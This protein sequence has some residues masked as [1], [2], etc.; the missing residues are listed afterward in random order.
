MERH[1][2]L[3]FIAFVGLF[4]MPFNLIKAQE[5]NLNIQDLTSESINVKASQGILWKI[6]GKGLTQASYI[7]AVLY[8]VPR[9]Q[10]FLHPSL[11]SV[12]EEID[13]V[14]MEVDPEENG[15]D[16]LFRSEVPIDSTLDVL[17]SKRDFK[18]MVDLIDDE[19][20]EDSRKKLIQRYPPL[21][22]LRQMM[23]DYCLYRKLGQE[24]IAYEE[25]L[26]KATPEKK[27]ISLQM[28]WVRL[29]WLD[30]HSF[31]EQSQ[32]M[33]GALQEREK[34]K[35][36]YEGMLRAYRQ[37]NLDRAWLLSLDSPDLGDNKHTLIDLKVANWKK[38]LIQQMPTNSV[39]AVAPAIALP[40]EYGLIH[41]LRKDGYKVEAIRIK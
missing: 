2:L 23:V 29:A 1:F 40:G 32:I 9:S 39:C 30:S 19:L 3:G 8:V 4:L 13:M 26:R 33:L 17:L 21:I 34:K 20:T 6:S 22:L 25:Y 18:L 7:Y 38:A 14:M 12:M 11:D 10:F 24:V 28:D 16:Y 27:F 5:S 36:A 35:M 37:G 31:H 41:L 15:R